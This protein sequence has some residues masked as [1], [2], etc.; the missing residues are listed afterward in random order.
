MNTPL[1][2]TGFPTQHANLTKPA[3]V[4]SVSGGYAWADQTNK[5]FYQF[6][7]E[8]P[9]GASP[10]DFDVWT[11]DAVLDQWNETTLVTTDK[12]LQRVSYGAG[13]QADEPGLGFYYGG[14]I[15]SRNTPGYAGL[16][17]ATSGIVRFD[18]STGNIK[19]STHPDGVG[20]AEGQMVFVPASDSGVLIY[21]GGIEDPVRNGS[22]IAVSSP[23]LLCV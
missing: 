22:R 8:F 13:T 10:T 23:H 17:L 2:G 19:N 9:Q 4:P 16:Q 15:N 20:R 3:K 12:S 1:Q 18:F 7:G 6:G 5:C 14:Y 11:Y 21:F